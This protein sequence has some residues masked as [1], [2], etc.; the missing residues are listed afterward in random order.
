M[1]EAVAAPQSYEGSRAC[2]PVDQGYVERDGVRSFYEVFGEGEPTILFLPTWSIAHSWV[3]RSQIAYFARHF[4]VIA[5]DGRGNGRSDRPLDPA[6]YAAGEFA[7]DALAVMDAT[8]TQSAITV[9]LSLG[10][11]WNLALA[12]QH[13]ERVEAAAFVGPT[14]YAVSE[15]YP[16]WSMVP[17]NERLDSYEG[18]CGQ[19]RHFIAEHYREFAEYWARLSDPMPHSTRQIEYGVGMALETTPE[20]LIAT[21][22]AGGA[23]EFDRMADMLAAGG[24]ML[25]PVARELACPVLV[26]EG[27]MDLVAPQPWAEALAEDSGGELVMIEEAGHHPGSR[28]PVRFNLELR[29][30]VERVA[31]QGGR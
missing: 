19:N 27:E 1:I 2:R 24:P 9:S 30:F 17:F 12:V 29:R 8:A 10:T 13:P 15:P 21:A 7:L 26:L 28:Q 6:A 25:Q 18:F 4:R 16:E 31:A 3:W 23:A 5:F 22:E 20:V 14:V 11:L